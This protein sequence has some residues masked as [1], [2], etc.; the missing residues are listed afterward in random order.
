[1]RGQ[2]GRRDS[3]DG[4][5]GQENDSLPQRKWKVAPFRM[6]RMRRLSGQLIECVHHVSISRVCTRSRFRRCDGIFCLAVV[7]TS[8]MRLAW[9][10]GSRCV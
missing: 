2:G 8:H 1:M 10:R 3:W 9:P 6:E 4:A 5:H 7:A